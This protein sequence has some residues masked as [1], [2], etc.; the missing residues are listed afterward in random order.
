ME[1]TTDITAKFLEAYD[2]L[3]DA[4]FKHCYFRVYDR[5]KAKD[6][7]Q[8]CFLRAWE[9]VAEGQDILNLKAFIFRIARNLVIDH[10]RKA[11][12]VSLD[13]MLEAGFAVPAPRGG[14]SILREADASLL[15][16]HLHKLEEPYR[17]AL[18]LRF[19]EGLGPSEIAHVCDETENAVSVRINRGLKKLRA[20][21]DA[22]PAA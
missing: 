5:E 21:F 1:Q 18:L 7:T 16:T 13:D 10:S 3:S 20:A 22:A 17:E 12:P 9:C 6:L 14:E 2:D 4:I 15:M 11:K 8:E 19:I